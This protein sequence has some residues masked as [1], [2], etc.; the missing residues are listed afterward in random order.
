MIQSNSLVQEL[1]CKSSFKIGLK[2]VAAIMAF[3]V[4]ESISRHRYFDS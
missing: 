3:A 4:V 2:C 1:V